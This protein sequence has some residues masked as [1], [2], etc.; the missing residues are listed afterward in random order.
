M[1]SKIGW[2]R[3]MGITVKNLKI[4]SSSANEHD[5]LIDNRDTIFWS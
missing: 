4:M 3:L 5:T 1:S 2:F